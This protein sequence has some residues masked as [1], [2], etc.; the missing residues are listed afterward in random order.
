MKAGVII[1]AGGKSSRMGQNKALLPLDGVSTIEKI[2]N[3]IADLFEDILIVANDEAAYQFLNLPIVKDKVRDKG[4]LAGIHAGLLAAKR[5]TNLIIACDMPFISP[6]IAKHLVDHS[7]GFDA[8]VPV[9]AGK[10]HPLFAVYNKSVL[11]TLENCLETEQLRMKHLLDRIHV[12]YSSEEDLQ[13]KEIAN[14]EQV[15]YNMNHPSEYE[16]AKN[17]TEN[18][19]SRK[20]EWG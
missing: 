13:I 12:N 14:L 20:K 19:N 8:V 3:S 2:K 1:L 9:I 5:E 7:E 6:Y 10:Q 18:S 4:P 17:M 15:F 16:E 11:P